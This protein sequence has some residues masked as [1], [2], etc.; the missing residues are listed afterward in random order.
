RDDVISLYYHAT[1]AYS[2]EDFDHL[3]SE[4]KE[5]CRKVYDELQDV[6]IKK[7]SCV[8]NPRKRYF[9]MTTNITESINSCLL[10][11]QKLPITT[12][13]ECIRD[14][15]QRWFYDRW[16][17]AREMSIYLT[18]FADEHIKEKTDTTQWCEIYPIHFNKFK[19]DD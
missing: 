2:I 3:M 4:L 14:L 9:F 6:G 8:H 12:M 5:T 7:F 19:V 1:Y 17:N 13:A 18:T 10:A 16:T 11:I 15:L